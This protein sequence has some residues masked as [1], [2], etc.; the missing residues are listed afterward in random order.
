M[1]YEVITSP[2]YVINEPYPVYRYSSIPFIS[3]QPYRIGIK[4]VDISF[5]NTID[6]IPLSLVHAHCPFTSGQIA[7][8]IA[9]NRIT[10]YN[11]CYTKLLRNR[12]CLPVISCLQ[13]IIQSNSAKTNQ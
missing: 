13:F 2:N 8:Q 11:V 5:Q 4:E 9:K 10:S 7:L 1:L 3:H 6:K 12:T